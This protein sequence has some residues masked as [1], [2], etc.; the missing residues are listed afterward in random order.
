MTTG[1]SDQDQRK[2][3]PAFCL[4]FAALEGGSLPQ[5]RTMD[6]R[7]SS[8]LTFPARRRLQGPELREPKGSGNLLPKSG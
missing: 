3:H 2:T 4:S 1:R 7:G 6:S 5:Y 8:C